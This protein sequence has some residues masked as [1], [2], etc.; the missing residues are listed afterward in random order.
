MHEQSLVDSLL[1]RAKRECQAHDATRVLGIE[2]AVGALSGVEPELLR[3][4][5]FALRVGT[6]C[7]TSTLS[8]TEVAVRWI[9][10]TCQRSLDDGGM[11]QCPICG[12]KAVLAEGADAIMIKSLDLEVP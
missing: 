1:A 5:F 4:A 7:E 6:V 10:A 12:A 8:L 2:L 3:S 11:L 9:C